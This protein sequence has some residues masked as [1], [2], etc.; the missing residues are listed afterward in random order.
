MTGSLLIIFRIHE[1]A[2]EV[3][4][5]RGVVEMERSRV[6]SLTKELFIAREELKVTSQNLAQK[7][8]KLSDLESNSSS[9]QQNAL[10]TSELLTKTTEECKVLQYQLQEKNHQLEQIRQDYKD[11]EIKYTGILKDFHTLQSEYEYSKSL[12]GNLQNTY[13]ENERYVHQIQQMKS[14]YD[15]LASQDHAKDKE[16]SLLSTELDKKEKIVDDLNVE[17]KELAQKYERLLGEL[18]EKEHELRHEK[19]QHLQLESALLEHRNITVSL[20]RELD[21]LRSMT[22]RDDLKWNQNENILK[23]QK[24]EIEKVCGILFQAVTRWDQVLSGALDTLD[25]P[26]SFPHAPTPVDGRGYFRNSAFSSHGFGHTPS[27]SPETFE[28]LLSSSLII[29][30]RV[31]GKL[32]RVEKI[33]NLFEKKTKEM[34]SAITLRVSHSDDRMEILSHKTSALQTQLQSVL[35]QVLNEKKIRDQGHQELKALQE[36]LVRG[37]NEQIREHEARVSELHLLYQAEKN[38]VTTLNH[39]VS[40]LGEE[41]KIQQEELGKLHEAEEMLNKLSVQLSSL[42]DSHRQLSHELEEKSNQV[43]QQLED[44][45]HLRHENESYQQNLTRLTSQIEVRDKMLNDHES[46]ISSLKVEIQQLQRRQINPELEKSIRESQDLLKYSLGR[47]GADY[48]QPSS[49]TSSTH[50]SERKVDNNFTQIVDRLTSL[51]HSVTKLV[52]ETSRA[53]K[54][55]DDRYSLELGVRGELTFAQSNSRSTEIEQSIYDLLNSN[56][57][58]ALQLQGVVSDFKR[59][60]ETSP[61]RLGLGE[62]HHSTVLPSSD[63]PSLFTTPAPSRSLSQYPSTPLYS[64]VRDQPKLSANDLRIESHPASPLHHSIPSAA[65]KDIISSRIP[66]ETPH[67]E[68]SRVHFQVPEAHSRSL[69]HSYDSLSSLDRDRQG[70]RYN[71]SRG[72]SLT[73]RS[74]QHTNLAEDGGWITRSK[75]LFDATDSSPSTPPMY[76]RSSRPHESSSSTMTSSSRRTLHLF[77]SDPSSAVAASSSSSPTPARQSASRLTKLGQDLQNLANRLDHFDVKSRR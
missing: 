76:P 70:E 63:M 40:V 58:L 61:P 46:L 62:S 3:I 38:K 71:S 41:I 31:Q 55:F 57:K 16:I 18:Q 75:L 39:E 15:L 50:L 56:A 28:D 36:S 21:N 32:E 35:T 27:P 37:H 72:T 47:A 69:R 1:K 10:K 52:D 34:M 6:E 17:K 67:S 65:R 30:E 44:I 9:S 29:I 59:Y 43:A 19:D 42:S 25:G 11:Y 20:Q 26:N 66:H 8:K 13:R 22:Q 54:S 7:D 51:Y 12:T 53:W 24:N 23:N 45:Q 64:A 60:L 77:P 4:S 68:H 48:S 73:N 14:D 33:R 5:L 2:E 74:T 49:Q